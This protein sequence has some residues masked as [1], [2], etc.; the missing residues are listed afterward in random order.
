[1][2]NGNGSTALQVIETGH[3]PAAIIPRTYAECE[4]Y[5]KTV[6]QSTLIPQKYRGKP[7][8]IFAAIQ[9]GAPL[10]LPPMQALWNV[11]V[12]Q[13][14]GRP[15]LYAQ[16]KMGVAMS[17]PDCIEFN[18]DE[19]RTVKGEIAV[20]TCTRMLHGRKV[21]YTGQ[22][23]VATAKRA[24]LLGKDNWAYVDDMLDKR[25]MARAAD[26]AYADILRGI[27][28]HDDAVTDAESAYTAPP[29]EP[30]EPP[31]EVE[32]ADSEAED[33]PDAVDADIVDDAA[34]DSAM[35]P[36]GWDDDGLQPEPADDARA[37][38][39]RACD[40]LAADM[41]AAPTLAALKEVSKAWTPHKGQFAD[42]D[43]NL[44]AQYRE[45]KAALQ[46]KKV[47]NVEA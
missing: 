1:M 31:A 19:K 21:V 29:P 41:L 25:A 27:G 20:W 26:A 2:A 10:G 22:F 5:C 35:L 40:Q 15:N 43:K 46:S 12:D 28:T 34:D 32:N 36:D 6:A 45:C 7:A 24:N 8:D 14:S 9:I 38:L 33:E 47:A 17:R 39:E 13:K 18:R 4:R 42:L 11:Y 30:T 37:E 23:D 16:A 3:A 44:L